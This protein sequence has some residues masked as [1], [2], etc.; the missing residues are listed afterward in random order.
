MHLVK[1]EN[2]ELDVISCIPSSRDYFN[3]TK[4]VVYTTKQTTFLP[5]TPKR[6][7]VYSLHDVQIQ[8]EI[9]IH[10]VLFVAWIF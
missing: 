6:P 4:K 5:L 2:S 9:L 3:N 7:S 8:Q 10:L 1:C